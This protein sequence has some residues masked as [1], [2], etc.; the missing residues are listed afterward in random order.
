MF[1]SFRSSYRAAKKTKKSNVRLQIEELE[2]RCLL[3][4]GLGPLGGITT[5]PDGYIWFLEKDRLGRID[6]H[7]GLIQEF[8][9]GINTGNDPSFPGSSI[10]EAPDGSIWFLSNHQVTRFTP[11]TN[12]LDTFNLTSGSS[13]LDSLTIGSDGVVWVL[14]KQSETYGIARIDPASGNV[15]NYAMGAL[16]PDGVNTSPNA[17]AFAPDGKIWIGNFNYGPEVMEPTTGVV[18]SWTAAYLP[19]ITDHWTGPLSTIEPVALGGSAASS[20]SF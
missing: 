3:S 20:E 5:G 15:Q 19:P 7:S 12:A 16:Q 9:Q 17:I 11:S 1:E 10:A 2:G 14:E 13:P 4:S 6:P 18:Q 8:A